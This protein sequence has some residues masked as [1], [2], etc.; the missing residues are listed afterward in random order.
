MF[1]S[2]VTR[3]DLGTKSAN[4][5]LLWKLCLKTGGDAT[6][7]KKKKKIADLFFLVV[8]VTVIGFQTVIYKEKQ[9]T[10]H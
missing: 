9:V 4:S 7:S 2:S 5:K 3:E 1:G 10:P 8:T 6:F